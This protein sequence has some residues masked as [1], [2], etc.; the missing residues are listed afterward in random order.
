MVSHPWLL[1]WQQHDPR[2]GEHLLLITRL[3]WRPTWTPAAFINDPCHPTRPCHLH[4]HKP[5]ASTLLDP[6]A[7][8]RSTPHGPDL[9]PRP[10]P[11]SQG[12][13]AL[14]PLG[15]RRQGRSLRSSLK[16]MQPCPAPSPPPLQSQKRSSFL[17]CGVRWE[18]LSASDLG[19]VG[20]DACVFVNT[21]PGP[22]SRFPEPT[23]TALEKGPRQSAFRDLFLRSANNSIMVYAQLA[24]RK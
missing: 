12:S 13:V 3:T 19:R 23:W 22:G 18:G 8:V 24:S 4:P 17:D 21:Q 5:S 7:C 10:P 6:L 14:P 20:R 15:P 16:R 11:L 1:D 9:C 2:A